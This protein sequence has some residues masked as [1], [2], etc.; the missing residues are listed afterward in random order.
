MN[1]SEFF[2]AIRNLF[3]DSVL[4]WA[5]RRAGQWIAGAAAANIDH[6]AEFRCRC[7]LI[8]HETGL[9]DPYCHLSIH[10]ALVVMGSPFACS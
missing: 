8:Y 1:I 6:M 9:D 10:T 7:P 5:T 4:C 2:A 3:V